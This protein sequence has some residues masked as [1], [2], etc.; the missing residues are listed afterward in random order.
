V[1][2]SSPTAAN[3]TAIASLA[4]LVGGCGTTNTVV[5]TPLET[6]YPVSASKQYVDTGGNVVREGDYEVVGSFELHK[7]IEG[8]LSDDTETPLDFE[9]DLDGYVAEYKGDAVTRVKIIG[10]DYDLGSME[11]NANLKFFGWMIGLTGAAFALTG[12]LIPDDAPPNE[13]LISGTALFGVGLATYF[14]SYAFNDPTSWKVHVSG[15]VVRLK[16]VQSTPAPESKSAGATG[17]ASPL[18][19]PPSELVRARSCEVQAALQ[20]GHQPVFGVGVN[21]WGRRIREIE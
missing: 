12:A 4:L 14:M 16:S 19:L 11:T 9:N 5:L 10:T 1:R 15:D 8:P 7:T 21:H 3:R 2:S 17:F 6:K 13:M 18:L 20:A